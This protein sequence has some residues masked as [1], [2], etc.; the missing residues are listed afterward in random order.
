MTDSKIRI[1]D[2]DGEELNYNS[3]HGIEVNCFKCW[4]KLHEKSA[5]LIS[6]PID[7]SS[8]NV[9]SV[10]K[11]HL[12]KSCFDLTMEFIMGKESP[13]YKRKLTA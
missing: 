9:D 12:C 8:D 3:I 2:E 4:K 13:N 5:I 7:T 6:P 11:M 10:Q 1:F